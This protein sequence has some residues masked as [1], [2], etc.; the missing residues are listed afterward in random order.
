MNVIVM[1]AEV[2]AMLMG[3]ILGGPNIKD[4]YS[5]SQ[6]SYQIMIAYLFGHPIIHSGIAKIL[7]A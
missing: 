1:V 2:V 3:L 4:C 6:I 5:L 7:L